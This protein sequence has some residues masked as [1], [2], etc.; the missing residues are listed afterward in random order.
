MKYVMSKINRHNQGK[1]ANYRKPGEV[2]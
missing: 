2:R 1:T